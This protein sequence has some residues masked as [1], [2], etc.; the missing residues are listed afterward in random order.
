MPTIEKPIESQD[1]TT[2]PPMT[3]GKRSPASRSSQISLKPRQSSEPPF[4]DFLDGGYPI[5]HVLT[6]VVDLEAPELPPLADPELFDSVF[7]QNFSSSKSKFMPQYGDALLKAVT[8][9]VLSELLGKDNL[10]VITNITPFAISNA[11]Y[12]QI[13]LHYG[14]DKLTSC[15]E[16]VSSEVKS[17]K[18]TTH[19]RGDVLEAYMAA[20]EKDVSRNGQGCREVRNWLLK[21]MALRLRRAVPTDDT[22]ALYSTG[23]DHQSFTIMPRLSPQR[24]SVVH[25]CV[26]TA[27]P[28]ISDLVSIHALNSNAQKS[29]SKEINIW[30]QPGQPETSQLVAESNGSV[31]IQWPLRADS[32][33]VNVQL[34][35]FRQLIFGYMR[36]IFYQIYETNSSPITNV[37]SFWV[38]L[39]CYLDDLQGLIYEEIELILLFYYRVIFFVIIFSNFIVICISSTQ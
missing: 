9:D 33:S 27:E 2:Q 29:Q 19:R 20:I 4:S 38:T 30:S 5:S 39:R 6:R 37:K 3:H 15:I 12:E 13:F 36:Q 32:A 16:P 35:H 22:N 10:K 8:F 21:V 26:E 14:L 11:F 24:T 7:F 25:A 31:M 1:K 23:T 28:I 18:G 34:H 17:S